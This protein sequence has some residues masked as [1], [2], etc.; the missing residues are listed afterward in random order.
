MKNN[1]S[2]FFLAGI[3][4]ITG[5]TS[6][7]LS[8]ADDEWYT[9]TLEMN[10]DGV[11]TVTADLQLP[12][13]LDTSYEVLS[14]YA[15]WPTLFASHSVINTVQRSDTLVTVD[16]TIPGLIFP[17][18]LQ[19]VTETQES[20]PLRLTTTLVKGDFDQYAWVWNLSSAGNKRHTRANLELS[21]KPSLWTPQWLFRI[22][23]EQE[24]T[25]HFQKLRHQVLARHRAQHLPSIISA[26]RDSR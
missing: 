24:L 23:L 17:L 14:D 13:P 5:I 15:H 22:M 12:T 19:L 18:N 26:A 7:V 25:E 2:R 1:T 11:A 8:D 21:V 4:L 3:L 20:P 9:Y 10:Q 6:P 16:M